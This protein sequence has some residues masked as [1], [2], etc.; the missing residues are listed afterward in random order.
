M[1]LGT[2]EDEVRRIAYLQ[3]DELDDARSITGFTASGL[4]VG[5]VLEATGTTAYGF[6]TRFLK[7]QRVDHSLGV[8]NT[9]LANDAV[10]SIGL[11]ASSNYAFEITGFA[12]NAGATDGVKVALGGTVGVTSLS[13][14]I[15]IYDNTTAAIVALGK[16]T[17]VD[18]AVGAGISAGENYFTIKGS[19]ETSTAGTLFLKYAQN[20]AG[21]GGGVFIM[22][23]T[24][25]T[26]MRTS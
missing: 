3:A 22:R 24:A 7:A 11:A 20:A 21:A 26:A 4:T 8:T 5:D 9:T 18:S 1:S 16:V 10:I 2:Q 14:E 23:G 15:I 13:A 6:V 25:I 12:D 17:A 19:I